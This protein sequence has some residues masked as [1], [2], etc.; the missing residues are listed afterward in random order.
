MVVNPDICMRPADSMAC[1]CW[2]RF[3]QHGNVKRQG[4]EGGSAKCCCGHGWQDNWNSEGQPRGRCVAGHSKRS[5]MIDKM[6]AADI[7]KL[8]ISEWAA[9]LVVV[10]KKDD[11]GCPAT[12]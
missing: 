1:D 4:P 9:N 2:C 3:D 12:L 10:P 8:Y 11:Q 7:V 5:D 6:I